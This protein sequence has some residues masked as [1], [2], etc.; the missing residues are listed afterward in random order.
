MDE[1]PVTHRLVVELTRGDEVTERL[2]GAGDETN[3][4]RTSAG[5][6]PNEY[7]YI[8]VGSG[9]A[10]SVLAA[11]LSEDSHKSVLLLEAGVDYPAREPM[12]D[13]VVDQYGQV[14]GIDGLR[15]V[16]ASI[17]PDTVRANLNLTVMA[18][19]E[20]MADLIGAV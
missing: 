5:G 13:A 11:R 9:S 20:R 7:D 14:H 16:D 10:G 12:P 1:V 3:C 19:A 8:V 4:V 15:I 17:M 6:M 2:S 18:M